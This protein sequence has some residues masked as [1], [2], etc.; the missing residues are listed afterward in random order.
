M[1]E[2]RVEVKWELKFVMES[3]N[4]KGMMYGWIWCFYWRDP[5]GGEKCTWRGRF[6]GVLEWRV[7]V[8]W[9]LKLME[10]RMKLM[11]ASE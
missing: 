3:R 5:V 10:S 9:E 11:L 1:L 7:E 2:W 4:S 8:K 6:S